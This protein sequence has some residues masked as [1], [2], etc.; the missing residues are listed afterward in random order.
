MPTTY[1]AVKTIS[2]PRG[3]SLVG[4]FAEVV[5]LDTSGRVVLTAAATD[6]P[7]G[8]VAESATT[9]AAGVGKQ[10]PEVGSPV[11]IVDL[12]GGGIA[13][14]KAGAAITA[15]QLVVLDS[16]GGRVAGVANLAAATDDTWILGVALE[17]AADGE[18]FS[19]KIQL[20]VA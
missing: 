4:D 17:A 2:L 13:M 18:I 19:F 3:A 9:P 7:I 16:T 11:S 10:T 15:G 20:A 5:K 14:V 12:E 1:Q 8:I 6:T